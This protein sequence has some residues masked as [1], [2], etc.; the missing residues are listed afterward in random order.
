MARL[1]VK[2]N[3]IDSGPQLGGRNFIVIPDC[4]LQI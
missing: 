4:F 1:P 2:G 3:C